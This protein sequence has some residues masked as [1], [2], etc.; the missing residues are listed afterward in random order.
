MTAA[1]GV[2]AAVLA[3]LFLATGGAKLL[4]HPRSRRIR[5]RFGLSP[6]AWTAI[7]VAE[8]VAAVGLLAGLAVPLLGLVAAVGLTGLVTG[9]VISRL[10]VNDPA[11]LVLF[12]VAVLGLV[13]AV[14]AL[15]ASD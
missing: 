4:R 13:W 5:D 3:L 2:L 7:G 1:L 8:C 6:A 9:A 12:D 10:R 15:Y 11:A 14:V